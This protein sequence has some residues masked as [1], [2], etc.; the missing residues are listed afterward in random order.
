MCI[1]SGN[2]WPLGILSA[3]RKR[4]LTGKVLQAG[5]PAIDTMDIVRVVSML[6][7]L[8]DEERVIIVGR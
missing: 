4:L 8:L 1:W 3:V 7:A 2:L 6:D 5:R